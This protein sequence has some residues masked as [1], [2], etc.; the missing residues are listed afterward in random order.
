MADTDY[1]AD[2][3][4]ASKKH[5]KKAYYTAQRKRDEK[6]AAGGDKGAQSELTKIRNK[7]PEAKKVQQNDVRKQMGINPEEAEGR[8]RGSAPGTM[9][10]ALAPMIAGEGLG[11]LMGPAAKGASAAFKAW[12]S[13]AARSGT[14]AAPKAAESAAKA[15]SKAGSK[16]TGSSTTTAKVGKD[17]ATVTHGQSKNMDSVHGP[18]PKYDKPAPKAAAPSGPPPVKAGNAYKKMTGK[19]PVGHGNMKAGDDAAANKSYSKPKPKVS[20]A[21]AP[22]ASAAPK[23][24]KT[25][26]AERTPVPQKT[27]NPAYSKAQ[28]DYHTGVVRSPERKEAWDNMTKEEREQWSKDNPRKDNQKGGKAKA[29]KS[30][31]EASSAP[32][33]PAKKKYADLQEE[34]FHTGDPEVAGKMSREQR[35]DF[36]KRYVTKEGWKPAPPGSPREA[37]DA[38][39]TKKPAA[40]TPKAAKTPP[41]DTDKVTLPEI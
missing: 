7:S 2:M 35:Q 22:K 18:A 39:A 8:N 38:A 12:G 41:P 4:A 10:A 28:N 17:T 1:A 3:K 9:K 20:E 21:P 32:A 14:E 23:A 37:S 15:M 30:K 16:S 13:K 40:K 26:K 33:A 19:S 25:P 11:R 31:S 27:P 5:D 6:L 34:L 36:A 24:G 29:K